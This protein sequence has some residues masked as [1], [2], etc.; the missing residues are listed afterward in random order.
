MKEAPHDV[1]V[2]LVEDNPGDAKLFE[3]YLQKANFGGAGSASLSHVESRTAAEEHLADRSPDVVFLDLG[4]PESQGLETLD[5]LLALGLD[6]PIIVLTGLDDH[7]LAVEAI[8]RGAQDY[9]VKDEI[10]PDALSRSVRYAIERHKQAR[11]LRRQKEQMEFFNQILRH[12]MLNGM[13]VIR[14]RALLLDREL[15][16]EHGAHV[17]SIVNW[18]DKI[19][20]LTRKVRRI[21]QSLTTEGELELDAVDLTAALEGEVAR[22]RTM[23]DTVTIEADVPDGVVVRADELLSDVFGNVLTNAVEHNDGDDVS[24]SVSVVVDDDAVTV[25]VEDDGSGIDPERRAAIFE[26][27]ETGSATG[28]GF[29][30]Y[31]VQSMVDVYGGDVTVTDS[32]QGG[33]RFEIAFQ[34]ASDDASAW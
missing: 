12:D 30:L 28:T 20:D 4:L 19:I 8:Q 1:D 15:G 17:D 22:V 23:T 14:E 25:I 18:S 3:R 13:N 34:P 2:L 7:E 33:A 29:G 16:D 31:F 32:E 27:G 5:S 10:N 26:R 21:L 9:L 11:Q 24:I 6:L